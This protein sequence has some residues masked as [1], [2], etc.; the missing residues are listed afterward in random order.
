MEKYLK[1]SIMIVVGLLWFLPL[2]AQ[3][4]Q[5]IQGVVSDQDG[6]TLE[7]VLVTAD[8]G[9][10]SLKTDA[11]GKYA[12]PLTTENQVVFF[13]KD[14]YS[15]KMISSNDLM[16]NSDIVLSQNPIL[17]G[18]DEK[19]YIPFGRIDRRRITGSVSSINVEEHFEKDNRV[20]VGAAINGSVPGVFNNWDL[21]GL[22][23]AKVIVDGIPR[24]AD[25][26]DL[27]EVEEITILKDPVSRMMYGAQSDKGVILITTKRGEANKRET[28]FRV[29]TGFNMPRELP[30]YLDAA[31]YMEA[32]NQANIND[33]NLAKYDEEAIAQ[34]RSGEYPLMYPNEKYYDDD[35]YIKDM[36]NF[37]SVKADFSGGN[38]NAQYYANLGWDNNQGW[39]NQGI[40]E[41]TNKF[42]IRGNVNYNIT[43]NLK[44]NIDGVALFDFYEA[45][46][47]LDVNNNTG[48]VE[49]DF[50]DK[51][52]KSLPN[53][54]PVLIPVDQLAS[55]DIVDEAN[56][57]DGQYLLGGNSIYSRSLYG[58]MLQRGTR[59]ETE[60]T[61]LFNTGL[62]WDLSFITEGL[63]AKGYVSFDLTNRFIT[64][65]KKEYAVYEPV[66][67]LNQAGEDSLGVNVIGKDVPSSKES[68]QDKESSFDRRIGAYGTLNYENVFGVHAI[69]ATGLAYRDQLTLVNTEQDAK[70][71][72]F[73][74][75]ANYMY[76]N[77]Y[78]A[79]FAGTYQGSQKLGD[80]EK[81]TMAPS[82][83]LGWVISE[84]DFMSTGLF[85]YLKLKG[86]Y[87]ILKNDNWDNYFLYKSVFTQDQWF[88]YGNTSGYTA[89]R[90]KELEYSTI[91]VPGLSWQKRKE[92]TLGFE[93]YLLSKKLWI[94]GGY[95]YSESYDEMTEMKNTY[96]QIM[97]GVSLWNNYG[98]QSD[99]G[100][101]AGIRYNDSFGDL[102]MSLGANM[103]YSVPEVLKADEPFY[104][105]DAQYRY[106]VGTESDAIW[107]WVA[108][109]LYGESDFDEFGQLSSDLPTPTFG[110]VQAGDIKYLDLNN[111]NVIDQDDQKPIGNNQARLQYSLNLHL[112]YKGFE[113]YALG[114]GQTGGES[115]R[116]SSYYW[117]YGDMKYS[118][119]ALNAYGPDNL[120]VNAEMP[121]L[122]SNKSNN[123]YRNSTYWMYSNNWFTLPTVQLGYNVG[124]VNGLFK[125]INIYVRGYNLVTL[126]ENVEMSDIVVGRAPKVKGGAAGVVATF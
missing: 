119:E 61:L 109:G 97:G 10:Y 72:H 64:L 52:E 110:N 104:A 55:S 46:D 90:N 59:K 80:D 77:K 87:G 26:F 16:V 122:S 100:Y 9:K 69:S 95:F 12:I 19:V 116:N 123:N 44:M 113:L 102:R 11:E 105:E 37:T 1:F 40:G 78:I 81:W 117:A 49:S 86:T 75:R 125:N 121:R 20:S 28:N 68:P 66:W 76:D 32:V 60:R 101:E 57:V 79:E 39:M 120:D 41:T 93:S 13:E 6:Q 58:D 42:N 30:E 25:D 71:L 99:K 126:G 38:E 89:T 33:G 124:A 50:W 85:D 111:D 48:A 103:V 74:L 96:P 94:E 18:E 88:N 21:L 115:L 67:L 31:E 53:A 108:D 35:T 27:F 51:M 91:G 83:G 23:G 15:T 17:M 65:Q 118:V 36:T 3:T 22:G 4:G 62:D 54:H 8:N 14:G 29:E 112:E 7:D 34:T 92:F 114:V 43:D 84:E 107:G 45:P 63:S 2:E 24:E 47:V 73:G 56:L 5:A 98:S 106:K 70:T 82:V